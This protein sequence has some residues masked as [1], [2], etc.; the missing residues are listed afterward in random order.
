MFAIAHCTHCLGRTFAGAGNAHRLAAAVP[1]GRRSYRGICR[2]TCHSGADRIGRG[3]TPSFRT[4]IQALALWGAVGAGALLLRRSG[5]SYRALGLKR[6]ASWWATIGWTAAGL[7]LAWAGTA[8]VG[9]AIHTLTNWPP[10]D[11]GYIRTSIEGNSA[12]WL[13]WMVLV[14]WGSAA[15][16]EELLSRGFLLDRFWTIAGRGRA[17][18]GVAVVLQA[19]TFGL[20]HAI[21][22]PTGIVVTAWIGLVFAGIWLAL[23][24]NLWA[25]ILAHGISDSD[26]PDTDLCGCA[27]SWL[28]PL[29]Q[30]FARCPFE[31][32]AKVHFGWKPDRADAP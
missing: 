4:P 16:G 28:H 22:G 23:G 25:P 19:T 24:R 21:Q 8:A 26:F 18:L 32:P 1:R 14:V 15:F 13:M 10:L 27:T 6:P 2:A 12:A 11:V 5:G 7:V 17:G 30:S 31:R 29:N 9:A 3:E 20:L